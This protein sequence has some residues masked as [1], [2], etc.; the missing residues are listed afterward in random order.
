MKKLNYQTKSILLGILVV[1][2]VLPLTASAKKIKFLQSDRGTCG[3]WLC[4][5]KNRQQQKSCNQD[6]DTRFGRCGKVADI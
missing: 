1:G 2:M 3:K 5:S 6:R 4:Q